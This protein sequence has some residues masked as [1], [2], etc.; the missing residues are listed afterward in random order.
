MPL[1]AI[2]LNS[3]DHCG[4]LL[5]GLA[6]AG[7][8]PECGNPYRASDTITL[9]GR[10]HGRRKWV[11]EGGAGAILPFPMLLLFVLTILFGA[12]RSRSSRV[13]A[14]YYWAAM[15]AAMLLRQGIVFFGT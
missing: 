9:F 10:T 13:P 11:P 2:P 14:L 15:G 3:C 12:A 7:T 6:E 4:Y 8:C 5:V 1:A